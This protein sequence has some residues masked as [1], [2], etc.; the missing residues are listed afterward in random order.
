MAGS[1]Q[2]VWPQT[3]S[4]S[5]WSGPCPRAEPGRSPRGAGSRGMLVRGC[6]LACGLVW[7]RASKRGSR[8]WLYHLSSVFMAAFSRSNSRRA[9]A[10]RPGFL[11]GWYKGTSSWNCSSAS[12][13]ESYE[14]RP[15]S[16]RASVTSLG[17]IFWCLGG[18]T[19][20]GSLVVE[21]MCWRAELLLCVYQHDLYSAELLFNVG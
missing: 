8:I 10:S 6:P 16:H 17:G 13:N 2:T 12:M 11:F 3:S 18:G 21:N 1:R 14:F 9:A 7:Y 19:D 15:S 5:R 20:S 4:R